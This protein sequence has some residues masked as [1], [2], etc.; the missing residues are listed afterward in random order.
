M[1]R[2]RLLF[3]LAAVYVMML[4]GADSCSDTNGEFYIPLFKVNYSS[5]SGGK[6]I[7]S[8]KAIA[9]GVKCVSTCLSH[10]VYEV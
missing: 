2:R 1:Q 5:L 9:I 8:F 4:Q 3:I 10:A 6:L 7:V